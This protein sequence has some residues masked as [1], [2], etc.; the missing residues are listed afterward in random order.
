MLDAV[1][2]G[3]GIDM[4][5]LAHPLSSYI[6]RVYEVQARDGVRYIAKFYRPGRWTRR[7]V[8]QEHEFVLE[9]ATEEIPV[10]A[11]LPLANDAT[12][13]ETPDGILFTVYPKGLGRELEPVADE[14]WRRLG[15]VVGRMHT[16]GQRHDADAR[17]VMHPRHSTTEDMKQLLDGDF[18]TPRHRQEFANLA[19]LILDRIAPLFDDVERIRIHGDC[20]NGNL[21]ERPEGILVIDFDD[22]A[23]GPPVQ[24]LWMLLPDHAKDSRRQINLILEGYE[25]FR[26]F[27]DATLKLIEPLRVMR[28]LYFLAWCSRQIEDPKFRHNFPHWGD[29]AFWSRE[30][31]DLTRQLEVID[32]H[33]AGH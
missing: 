21:L 10:V 18:V 5:G 4:T 20:H 2:D 9:C 11:P 3:L 16:V 13:G 15:R 26:E 7:A 19:N 8:Q 22:M 28:I 17:V 31:N 12:L 27:D 33:L 30:I 1:E 14:D 23:M 32:N 29:D 24:D 25:D 6:N